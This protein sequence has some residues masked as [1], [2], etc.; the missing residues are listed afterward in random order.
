VL[1]NPAARGVSDRFD[2]ARVVRYLARHDIEARLIVPASPLEATREAAESA[3][4]ADDL[5]F[6]VGG[7]GSVRDA[8]LGLAGSATALA[9]IPA[10]TVNIWAMEAGIPAGI[11]RAFDAHISGRTVH[12][13]L[14]RADGQCFLLMAGIGWDAE[15]AR[16]VPAWLKR[17]FGDYAYLTQAAWMLPH[18]RPRRARWTADG[19]AFE[20]PLAWMVLGNTRLYGG[21]IRLTPDAAIDDSQLDLIA[22]CPETIVDGARLVAKLSIRRFHDDERVFQARAGEVSITTPG[23]AV[24]LD[25]DFIGETP[26]TFSIDPA[27]LLVSLPA[28]RLPEIFAARHH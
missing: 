10:G 18:L 16:R 24:Q 21:R 25:G 14:G 11:K 9:A 19:V 26:M 15:I 27:A 2:A 6:V 7:D 3:R 17:R 8:A 28:G 22:L 5:V 4:R 20:E 13:D 23:V 1:V 12:M